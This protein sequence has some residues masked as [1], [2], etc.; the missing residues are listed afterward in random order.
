MLTVAGLADLYRQDAKPASRWGVG[1]EIE[2]MGV[3]ASTGRPI[4][5]DAARASVRSVLEFLASA[6]PSVTTH[7]GPNLI[8]LEGDWGTITLEPGG[9]L[10]WS[11]HPS[12]TLTALSGRLVKHLE[13][14][15]SSGE[16]LG[17]RWLQTALQP[18]TPLSEMPWMP[19]KRYGIMREYLAGRGTLGHRMMTQTTSMQ[20]ALDYGDEDDWREKFRAAYLIAPVVVAAFANSRFLEG[21]DTGFAS[22]RAHIWRNTDNDRCGAPAFVFRERFGFEDWVD[23]LLDVPAMF[24]ARHGRLY[25]AQGVPWR[26]ILA[27]GWNGTP[28][29]LDDWRLHVTEVFPEAR[30]KAYVELRS[31]DLVPNDRLM[32]LPAFYMGLLYDAG[33]RA[34]AIERIGWGPGRRPTPAGWIEAMESAARDGL[35]ARLGGRLLRDVA[36]EVF[37]LARSALARREPEAVTFLDALP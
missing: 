6:R 30:T 21:N 23:W 11:S 15:D 33:A 18:D 19:K 22:F 5:Y 20:V 25:P 8:A 4:P 14:L 10:E 12:P 36:R 1:I 13:L 31:A 9:Q 28:M 26:K 17:I 32:A 2:K 34:E 3:D 24:V 7:E 35:E 37:D 27:E 29:T 16:S